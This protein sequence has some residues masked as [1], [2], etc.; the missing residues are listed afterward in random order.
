[1]FNLYMRLAAFGSQLAPGLV[2]RVNYVLC[3]GAPV[4]GSAASHLF[5]YRR[6]GQGDNKLL[7]CNS[8]F[9]PAQCSLIA[10]CY[11]PRCVLPVARRCPAFQRRAGSH[12]ILHS[13]LLLHCT[14]LHSVLHCTVLHSVL[15]C[16]VLHSA[17]ILHCPPLCTALHCPPLC[18][19][20]CTLHSHC[21]AQLFYFSVRLL[22][23]CS[24]C[25]AV[26][27]V[28]TLNNEE[29]MLQSAVC[30]VLCVHT[31][32]CNVHSVWCARSTYSSVQ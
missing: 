13:A 15:H 6:P 19:S 11:R 5:S 22:N 23:L 7:F 31:P 16:T 8:A 4:Q 24:V 28:C 21:T 9:P 12:R 25:S 18:T 26:C 17:L 30:C 29:Y 20:L 1:M 10:Q 32:V 2:I 27:A 3:R 14:V